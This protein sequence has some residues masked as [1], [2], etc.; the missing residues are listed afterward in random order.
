ML[1]SPR[2]CPSEPLPSAGPFASSVVPE[3]LEELRAQELRAIGRVAVPRSL[4]PAHRGLAQFLKQEKRRHEKSAGERWHWDTPKFESTL[5]KR[6]LRILN[7]VFMALGKRGHQGEA[8]E[9]D[10]EIHARAVIGD[11]HI[12]LELDIAG[13]GRAVR[14]PSGVRPMP[15]LPATTRL[16]FRVDPNF[17]GRSD[18]AWQDD[19]DG[20]IEAKIASITAAIIVA[21]ESKFRRGLREAEERVEQL[22]ELNEKKRQEELAAR[23]LRRL[24]AL[25]TSSQLLQQAEEI[26]ALV[27]RVH[28][29]MT[30]GSVAC[31]QKTVKAWGLWASAEADRIDPVR[32]CQVLSQLEERSFSSQC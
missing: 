11:T 24:E 17:D 6:R 25:R 30:D 21:G 26:R 32:S 10:G 29:A 13:R 23:N 8:H 20:T 14:P 2:C 18:E 16:A 27:T 28:Q 5:D 12:G 9:R 19:D 31:D 4:E 22:R 15:T 3:E 7:A 1:V